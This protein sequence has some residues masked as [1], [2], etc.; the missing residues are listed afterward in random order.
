MIQDILEKRSSFSSIN[1]KNVLIQFYVNQK[2]QI[3]HCHL[4]LA[5]VTFYWW[6]TFDIDTFLSEIA[7]EYWEKMVINDKAQFTSK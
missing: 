4:S 5:Y 7:I 1:L 6:Y 2:K 3:E